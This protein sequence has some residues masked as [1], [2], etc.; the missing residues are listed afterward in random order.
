MKYYKMI[1]I[2]IL[3]LLLVLII[4]SFFLNNNLPYIPFTQNSDYYV[5]ELPDFLTKEECKRIIEISKPKL[6]T[7]RVY[8]SDSDLEDKNVRISEQ[9]WLKNDDDEFIS[10]LSKRIADVTKMELKSQ[11]DLQVVK[12]KEGGFYKPHFDACNKVTDDCTR[13]NKGLGPRFI[14][15]IIYLNDDFEG[16]ETFFPHINKKVVPKM[17]KAAIF[18]NVDQYGEVLPKSLHGG[19][20]V[21]NGEKWICNKWI[22]LSHLAD[23]TS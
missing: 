18:Y 22:R 21:K 19:L 6:F 2:L 11:E 20:D 7:S 5:Q 8:S 4:S 9:C 13:L 16:G 23:K 10:I 12:Y 14:T 1:F 17:G 15:F 3:I